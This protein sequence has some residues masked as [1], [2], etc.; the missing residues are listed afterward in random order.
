MSISALHAELVELCRTAVSDLIVYPHEWVDDLHA[1][2]VIVGPITSTRPRGQTFKSSTHRFGVKVIVDP[3]AS[4]DSVTFL[5]DALDIFDPNSLLS[6]LEGV[7]RSSYFRFVTT[8][9]IEV[10][11]IGKGQGEYLQATIPVVVE[12]SS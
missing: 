9:D 5:H 11:V 7:L 10:E 6:R 2:C 12:A 3:N 4:I 1:P 8:D